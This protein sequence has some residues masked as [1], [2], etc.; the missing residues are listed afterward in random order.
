MIM[1]PISKEMKKL[2]EEQDAY[3]RRI[4]RNRQRFNIITVASF[5]AGLIYAY[6]TR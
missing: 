4:R 3:Q 6:L 1:P 5:I 2:F